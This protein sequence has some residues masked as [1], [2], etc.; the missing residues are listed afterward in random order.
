MDDDNYQFCVG[1]IIIE[2]DF[3]TVG[4][5]PQMKG[6]IIAIKHLDYT[7]G[8]KILHDRL[9][10]RWLDNDTTEEMPSVL[11]NLVSSIKKLDE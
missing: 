2:K 3:I 4:D 5:A 8:K 10:I 6:I 7:L 9:T 1:D 11:V